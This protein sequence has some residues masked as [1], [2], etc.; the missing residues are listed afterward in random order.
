MCYTLLGAEETNQKKIPVFME[1][2]FQRKIR[3]ID[4]KAILIKYV[5]SD[6]DK[7]YGGKI[8]GKRVKSVG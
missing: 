1:H 2:T 6:D 5:L 4:G 7:C 8:S 3:E